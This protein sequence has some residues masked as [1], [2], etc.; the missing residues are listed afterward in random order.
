VF[1]AI[2]WVEVGL[3]YFKSANALSDCIT[4]YGLA[5]MMT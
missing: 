3:S 1:N 5:D 4:H 2:D